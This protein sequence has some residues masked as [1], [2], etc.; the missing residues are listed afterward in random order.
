MPKNLPLCQICLC[1][2]YLY[3][4]SFCASW[5]ENNFSFSFFTMH[6]IA[7]ET[8]QLTLLF[9]RMVDIN[10]PKN[11][12]GPSIVFSHYRFFTEAFYFFESVFKKRF[13]NKKRFWHFSIAFF[14][15]WKRFWQVSTAFFICKNAFVKSQFRLRT[16]PKI[17]KSVFKL[18]TLIWD[19]V[20]Q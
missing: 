17:F 13:W 4:L 7:V 9:S 20:F 14:Q 15:I 6:H 3:I 11:M 16:Q 2:W 12:S 8:N 10:K 5:L 19:W 18:S 1:G